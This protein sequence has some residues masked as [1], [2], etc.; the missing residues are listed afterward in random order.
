MVAIRVI[1]EAATCH[2]GDIDI[3]LGLIE[4]ASQ[5]GADGIKFQHIVPELLYAPR[6]AIDGRVVANPAIAQRRKE[7]LSDSELQQLH[8]HAQACGIEFLLT[9]FDLQSLELVRKLGLRTVKIA[10]GDLT[11]MPL[12]QAVLQS[13]VQ[14]L[15]STGMSPISEVAQ[16]LNNC[17]DHIDGNLTLLHCTSIYPCPPELANLERIQKLKPF[18]LPVGYS[19]HTLGAWA[20]CAAVALG[21]TTIEKHIR[22][23]NGPQTADFAHS[24]TEENFE[25]FVVSIRNVSDAVGLVADDPSD[26]ELAVKS[27][28]RRGLYART[29][30][31]AGHLISQDDLD[32]LRPETDVNV[33]SV[34]T[35]IGTRLISDI[36]EGD[37][38]LLTNLQK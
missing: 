24:M 6:L 12:V 27:R 9:I 4:L 32:F 28:A 22:L 36:S 7:L 19:D 37:P 5:G 31:A 26:A 34:S 33:L 30:L 17:G 11:F 18:G 38:I 23:K 13:G 35:I 1:A 2:G 29:N 14:V 21:A 10:S 15:L 3:A 25:E 20:S 8:A 16:V